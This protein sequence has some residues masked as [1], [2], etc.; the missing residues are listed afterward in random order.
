MGLLSP[1]PR[2]IWIRAWHPFLIQQLPPAFAIRRD[3]TSIIPPPLRPLA[4]GSYPYAAPPPQFPA[5]YGR[6]FYPQLL[7]EM[8]R[9]VRLLVRDLCLIV[10][11][12]LRL[13]STAADL[14]PGSGFPVNAPGDYSLCLNR[15]LPPQEASIASAAESLHYQ[16][17]LPR[18]MPV[19]LAFSPL[20]MTLLPWDGPVSK[21]IPPV[22]LPF[23]HVP[24]A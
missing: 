12:C 23:Q 22:R 11:P 15:I 4:S 5:E 9:P 1:D 16:Y 14:F 20:P 24:G 6:N 18:T 8:S 2:Q 17:L 7:P 19:G 10:Q 21:G 3:H 13:C